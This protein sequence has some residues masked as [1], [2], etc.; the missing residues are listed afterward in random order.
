MPPLLVER[1]S[2]AL[3]VLTLN[4]PERLNALDDSLLSALHELLDQL[5][6]DPKCRVVI[7]TGAGRG[8]CSGLDLTSPPV[9]PHAVGVGMPS[10]G[11]RTQEYI[12]SLV[13]KIMHLPQTVIAAVNGPTVGG[14]LALVAACDLRIGS[15]SAWFQ[16]PFIRMGIS[17]GDIGVS[18]TL[19]RLLGAARAAELLYTGREFDAEEASRIG[20]ISDVVADEDLMRTARDLADVLLSHSPF[21]LEMTKQVLQTNFNATNVESAIALEIRT[22][23]LAGSTGDFF[24][25][26]A[27]RKEGR[28]PYCAAE[29]PAK[30]GE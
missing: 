1:P 5:A 21:A 17:A 14:G 16:A 4:R 2:D 23:V 28:K 6:V 18:F 24:E 15:Q 11:T 19:P 9:A 29:A 20:F 27:A 12:T 26:A 25:A 10:A 8:F 3:A 30:E 22:Q 7:I 13:P